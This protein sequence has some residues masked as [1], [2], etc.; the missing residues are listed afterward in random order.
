MG[1]NALVI[2]GALRDAP[3]LLNVLLEQQTHLQI[4]EVMTDT[5]GY[6][7]IV[8]GLFWLLGY[9]FSPRLADLKDMRFW[10]IDPQDD[11]A[12]LNDLGRHTISTKVVIEHWDEMLRLAGSL[13]WEPS[14]AMRSCAGCMGISARA[15]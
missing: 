12:M 15:V 4:K 1:F 5:A 9:Q 13:K 14:P 7:D 3:Y 6:S 8:F 10:R 2:P 11:Y